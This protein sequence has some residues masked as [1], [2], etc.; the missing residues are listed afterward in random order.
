[1]KKM[2]S[3]TGTIS[4]KERNKVMATKYIVI[5][6][7]IALSGC[8]AQV[9]EKGFSPV[10]ATT[11]DVD[12][13]SDAGNSQ[14]PDSGLIVLPAAPVEDDSGYPHT[15]G[16]VSFGQPVPGCIPGVRCPS[17]QVR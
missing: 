10:E 3:T 17:P 9:S 5:G 12:T 7:G 8:L 2:T 16:G 11:E 14:S 13:V 4:N 15:S 1:M 6:L